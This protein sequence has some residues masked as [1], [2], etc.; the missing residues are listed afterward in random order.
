MG[1]KRHTTL[2]MLIQVAHGIAAQFGKSCE[3]VI[4][5]L[6]RPDADHSIVFIEN[7]HVTGRKAGDG[8]S[9]IVLET[10]RRG[11]GAG[12]SQGAP[13][14]VGTEGA[15]GAPGAA[16]TEGGNGGKALREAARM[17]DRLSYLT[18]TEGGRILK[19]S[20]IFIRGDGEGVDYILAINYD[21]TELLAVDSALRGLLET[22]PGKDTK[23]QKIP[24]DVSSL[25]DSLIEQSVSLVGKPA[26]T[27]NKDEKIAAIRFLNDAG[28]FLVTRSGDKISSYFGISKFTLYSYL[29]VIKQSGG[30]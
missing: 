17:E 21:I 20:T 15:S 8:P 30:G 27:M 12:G 11:G 22:N 26:A 5:D 23:P 2:D 19:S 1:M 14:T 7:G 10:M 29:D 13:G 16:G 4:H 18:R 9:G 6:S 28:A 25:L 24:Q 3:V